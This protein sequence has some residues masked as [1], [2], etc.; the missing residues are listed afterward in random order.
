MIEGLLKISGIFFTGAGAA[1]LGAA[2]GRQWRDHR[3]LLEDLRKMILLLRGEIL[4]QGAPL[5]EAFEKAGEKTECCLGN[6]FR[7]TAERLAERNGETFYNI[8][9][10]EVDSLERKI[11]LSA[12]DRQ[13]LKEFGEHLGYLD[14]DMQEKTIHLYIQQLDGEISYLKEHQRERSRLCMSLGMAGGF[15]LII[16]L[17]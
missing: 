8:W 9:K 5:E 3:K 7:K 2:M 11:P 4:Y 6:L 12:S 15:F 16:V 14:R 13:Q 1:G 10:A 17:C